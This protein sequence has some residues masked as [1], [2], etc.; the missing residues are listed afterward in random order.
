MYHDEAL[1]EIGMHGEDVT[2]NTVLLVKDHG[3]KKGFNFD[4]YDKVGD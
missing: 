1:R 2:N 4:E 3:N